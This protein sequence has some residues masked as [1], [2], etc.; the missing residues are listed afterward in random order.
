[1]P[2]MTPAQRCGEIEALGADRVN[3]GF[4]ELA[5]LPT[6][7]VDLIVRRGKLI[8]RHSI[9]NAYCRPSIEEG[10]RAQSALE[11]KIHLCFRSA[12]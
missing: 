4:L 5:M 2:G 9:E 12:S 3:D 10:Y 7:L 6:Q 8:V 1:M 11:G